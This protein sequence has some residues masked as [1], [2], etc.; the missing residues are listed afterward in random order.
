MSKSCTCSSRSVDENWDMIHSVD[1][2]QY[3][4]PKLINPSSTPIGQEVWAMLTE[5]AAKEMLP[6][7]ESFINSINADV[8][9]YIKKEV[10]KAKK[11][12]LRNK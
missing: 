8:E 7:K 3:K 4:K 10:E 6:L 1:C 2:P 9:Y 5:A 11:S 12:F